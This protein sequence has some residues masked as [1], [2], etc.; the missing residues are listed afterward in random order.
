M[1][2]PTFEVSGSV[3]AFATDGTATSF[4][5]VPE[6]LT[7]EVVNVAG[8][9]VAVTALDELSDVNT[10]GVSNGDALVYDS[11]TWVPGTVAGSGGTASVVLAGDVVGTAVAGTVT[12][13]IAPSGVTAGTYGSPGTAVVLTVGADGRITS[14]A[15]TAIS[16]G[17]SSL[18]DPTGNEG[19]V[20]VVD[21]G[22]WAPARSFTS[23]DGKTHVIADDTTGYVEWVDGDLYSSASADSTGAEVL[24]TDGTATAQVRANQDGTVEINAT[25]AVTV[26]PGDGFHVVGS[27][28]ETVLSGDD[29]LMSTASDTDVQAPGATFARARGSVGSESAVTNGDILAYPLYAQGH[30]GTSLVLAGQI[31][32]EVDGTVATGKVPTLLRLSTADADGVLTDR[33]VLNPDNTTELNG[34]LLDL[35]TSGASTG[36]VATWDGTKIVLDTPTGGGG[37][38]GG[39]L[40][41]IDSGTFSGSSGFNV[42]GVFD[43]TYDDYLVVLVT[44]GSTDIQLGFRL[45]A[46]GTDSSSNY[47]GARLFA[48]GTTA[49]VQVNNLGSDEWQI[50]NVGLSGPPGVARLDLYGPAVAA[51]SAMLGVSGGYFSSTGTITTHLN[52]SHDVSTAYDGFAVRPDAGTITGRWAVYGYAK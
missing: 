30:D 49:G 52:G 20:L 26:T 4:S 35:D 10:S 17:G 50:N 11:G 25:G 5:V 44:N 7:F 38:G 2:S 39:G 6:A 41:L 27:V 36:D 51:P 19:A 34:T 18:P 23:P 40:V 16:G 14:I 9:T 8:Y 3:V 22:A 21:T 46:S 42:D 45:R 12:T 15:G 32:A 31:T 28:G 13:D 37:G 29:Y 48:Y 24:A 47:S 43:S 1:T 33:L